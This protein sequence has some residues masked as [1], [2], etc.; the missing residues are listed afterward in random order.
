MT[1]QIRRKW[2]VGK[3]FPAL[4][5]PSIA[6][7]SES[8]PF[9]KARPVSS[10]WVNDFGP[11]L[12]EITNIARGDNQAMSQRRRGDHAVEHRQRLS[13]PL[14]SDDQGCPSPTDGGIPRDTI[15]GFNDISKP[16]FE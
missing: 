4:S 14:Q 10:E 6:A 1:L 3:S 15:R 7:G 11:G 2:S 5:A 13:F 9:G 12:L 8:D 16:L